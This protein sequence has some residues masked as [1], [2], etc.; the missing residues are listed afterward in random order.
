MT[1]S[2]GGSALPSD[3]GVVWRVRIGGS[4]TAWDW[5]LGRPD[6]R[7][8]DAVRRPA[9]GAASKH[10]PVRAYAQTVGEHLMLE[11]GLEH[12]L[13]RVLDREPDVTWIVPQPLQL[14]WGVGQ[15]RK[16]V[17]DL[18][19][20]DRDCAVTVWD[21]KTVTAAD[22]ANFDTVRRVTEQACASAGW[23]YEV[24]S[25]LS[26]VHRHNLVWLHAYRSRPKWADRCEAELLATALEGSTLG[27][28]VGRDPERTSLTWHLIWSGRLSADLTCRLSPSTWVAS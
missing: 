20:V 12:D 17:P 2:S 24:F 4:T 1:D 7:T 16:H 15:N 8:L 9:S 11:S 14:E 5:S 28:L 10:V 6:P 3:V 21:V 23:K 25:G 22:S 13:V 27:N 18:L 19:A 26:A